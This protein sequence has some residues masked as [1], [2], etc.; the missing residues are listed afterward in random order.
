MTATCTGTHQVPGGLFT[1]RY[2]GRWR[3]W[4]KQRLSLIPQ[5]DMYIPGTGTVVSF[6][7]PLYDMIPVGL[8]FW[9]LLL[10]HKQLLDRQSCSI[11]S[12]PLW[13]HSIPTTLHIPVSFHL[14]FYSQAARS[15]SQP[16]RRRSS[17]ATHLLT[18]SLTHVLPNTQKNNAIGTKSVHYHG[19]VVPLYWYLP[20]PTKWCQTMV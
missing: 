20:Q 14:L 1:T 5:Y 6:R 11:L 12:T 3:R 9:Y 18:H 8:P 2:T 13:L 15:N 17:S 4:N 16:R 10:Y 7:L 19:T